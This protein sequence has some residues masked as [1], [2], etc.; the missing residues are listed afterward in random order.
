ML[1][2]IK[3]KNGTYKDL[4]GLPRYYRPASA[5]RHYTSRHDF[6]VP[7]EVKINKRDA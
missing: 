4:Q 5:L 6:D 3:P 1:D 7:F 2:S